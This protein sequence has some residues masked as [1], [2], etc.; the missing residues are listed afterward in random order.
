[1]YSVYWPANLWKLKDNV[2]SGSVRTSSHFV[3]TRKTWGTQ[4]RTLHESTFSLLYISL[5]LKGLYSPN[6]WRNYPHRCIR[7]F[8][9]N[10]CKNKNWTSCESV[11]F[12]QSDNVPYY[13]LFYSCLFYTFALIHEGQIISMLKVIFW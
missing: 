5:S 9:W 1:M 10:S 2:L 13:C 8:R 6:L 11:I 4:V 12:G 3:Y 7:E